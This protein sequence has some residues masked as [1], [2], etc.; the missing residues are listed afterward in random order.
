MPDECMIALQHLCPITKH[1]LSMEI[2]RCQVLRQS[3]MVR[4]EVMGYQYSVAVDFGI[5]NS[6]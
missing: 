3:Y 4:M 5:P 6:L 2:I 1:Q